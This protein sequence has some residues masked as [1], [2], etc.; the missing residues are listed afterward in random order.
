VCKKYLKAAALVNPFIMV[1][2]NVSEEVCVPPFGIVIG[3][4]V[5]EMP[6]IMNFATLSDVIVYDLRLGILV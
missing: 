3:R 2:V 4:G 1:V 5:I 6:I